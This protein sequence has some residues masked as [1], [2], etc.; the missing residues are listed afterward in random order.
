MKEMDLRKYHRI[1][2]VILSFFIILQAGSGLLLTVVE[3]EEAKAYA[4]MEYS[5]ETHDE[6]SPF[7]EALE[8]LHEKGGVVGFVLRLVVGAGL[9]MMASSGI[10][11]FFKIKARQK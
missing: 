10:L 1:F 2:G 5:E 3:Y 4:D 11:I 9:V 6:E 7:I 8:V